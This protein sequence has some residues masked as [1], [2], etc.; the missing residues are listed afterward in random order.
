MNPGEESRSS[1]E[2]IR[3]LSKFSQPALNCDG[4]IFDICGPWLTHCSKEIEDVFVY[5]SREKSEEAK[6][7]PRTLNPMF[8]VAHHSSKRRAEE[9]PEL[10]SAQRITKRLARMRIGKE[11]E[12]KEGITAKGL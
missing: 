11:P 2:S 8:G 3:N 12:K 4:R 10:E 6:E 1:D 5:E 9:E 7:W